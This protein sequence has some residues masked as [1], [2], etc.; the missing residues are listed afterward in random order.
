[1]QSPG[2]LCGMLVNTRYEEGFDD[3]YKRGSEVTTKNAF[4]DGYHRG[5]DKANGHLRHAF[6]NEI[7]HLKWVIQKLESKPENERDGDIAQQNVARAVE[8]WLYG[9]WQK[10]SK[11]NIPRLVRL[12]A[13]PVQSLLLL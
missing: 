2:V 9:A 7:R 4:E 13:L 6:E 12:T 3:G 10:V 5:K 11:D 1:M 8:D